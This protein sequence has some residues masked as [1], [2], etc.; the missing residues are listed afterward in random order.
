M[1]K[2]LK[3][4]NISYTSHAKRGIGWSFRLAVASILGLIHSILPFLFITSM[5]DEVEKLY[6]EF[7]EASNIK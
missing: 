1:F 7:L 6:E 3:D 2:H 5:S 4:H